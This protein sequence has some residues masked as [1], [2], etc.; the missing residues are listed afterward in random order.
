MAD[1]NINN[2]PY[3]DLE[4]DV[5]EHLRSLVSD[6]AEMRRV[7]KQEWLR[8][9]LTDAM[10]AARKKAGMTQK[11]VA[12]EL[13]VS[14]S[15]VSKLESA[16]YDHQIESVAA[17]LDAIG[18]ELLMAVRVQDELIPVRTNEERIL[19][20]L[21]SWYESEAEKCGMTVQE[22]VRSSI[23]EGKATV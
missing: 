16:N 6:T 14:Q 8:L 21:P 19:V 1:A 3:L 12:A 7:G 17:H 22:Y 23:E 11:E 18:A 5:A 20:E 4:T 15:W 13:E 10:I 9:M 2:N